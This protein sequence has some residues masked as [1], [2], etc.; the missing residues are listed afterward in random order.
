MTALPLDYSERAY[1]AVL[2]KL[3]GVYLGRPFEGWTYQR[4]MR[5]L[6]PIEDYVHE[7]LNCPLVVTDDD[8][9]GTFT[10]IRALED[11]GDAPR[12]HL[13][14]DRRD[15]AQLHCRAPFDPVVG[16]QRQLDRAHRLAQS[17]A[18]DCGAGQRIDRGQRPGRR[19]ADRRADLHR[20]MGDRRARKSGARRPARGAGG[21]GEPRRRG[22]GRGEAL[23]GDGSRGVHMPRRRTPDRGRPCA[24]RVGRSDREACRRH[25][26]VA[27]AIPGLARDARSDRSALRIRQVS[28]P[29]PRHSQS[30][31]HDHDAA[32]RSGRLRACAD[33]R[34]HLRLGHGLQCGQ[35]RL[36]HGRHARPRRHRRRP[37]M[38]RAARRPHADLVRGRRGRDQRRG[39]GERATCRPWTKA[40]GLASAPRAKGRSA[41][42]F[43][44]ARQRAGICAC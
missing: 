34:L 26:R 15:L 18:G 3:I 9:A 35:R 14:R 41:V 32:L 38:A 1:A 23:G 6:G 8:V 40:G 39:P 22:G 27:K 7:R 5:E 28:G 16:R 25:S 20:R 21:E 31:A 29:L 4:I 37:Q 44:V 11:H 33:D 10:F 43:L 19:R 12:S 36:P 42:P 24:D 2:G 13:A 17:E 30:R